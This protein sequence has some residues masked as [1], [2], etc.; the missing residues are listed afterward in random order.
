MTPLLQ[1]EDVTSYYGN[2]PILRNLGITIEKGSCMCVL[3]RNGVGKTTLVRTIMGLVDKMT[4]RL[5]MDGEDLT[6]KRTDQRAKHGLGYIP[7]GRQILG[8]FTIRENI[9]LGSFAREDGNPE[10]PELCLELFPYLKDNLNRRAG[11]LSGGQKQQLAIARALAVDPKILILDEPTEGIQPNIVKEIGEML[12]MLNR[13]M[14]ITLILTEQHIKVAR[15]LGD[16]FVM[17]DNGE[18][19]E[20]G[21]ISALTDDVVEKHLTV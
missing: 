12:K 19:V 1:L 13:K 10:I 3:G 6:D 21:P 18:I 16:K 17:M 11:L 15:D 4:G 20:N 5:S 8:D 2:T 14:G 7:Q 9:L